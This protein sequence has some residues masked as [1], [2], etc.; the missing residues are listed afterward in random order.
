MKSKKVHAKLFSHVRLSVTLYILSLVSENWIDQ[1]SKEKFCWDTWFWK[2]VI[3]NAIVFS[4]ICI[5]MYP[6]G[7]HAGKFFSKRPKNVTISE[8]T[9]TQDK[10]FQVTNIRGNFKCIDNVFSIFISVVKLLPNYLWRDRLLFLVFM[11]NSL[12]RAAN[13][14]ETIFNKAMPRFKSN[15]VALSIISQIIVMK[16]T[17]SLK[18]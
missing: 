8:N 16:E 14:N 2:T 13:L 3:V 9:H 4:R 1:V 17:F 12:P 11:M 18:L 7:I 5:P 6:Q 15:L 10:G